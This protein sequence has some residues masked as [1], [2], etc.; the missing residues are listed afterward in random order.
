MSRALFSC[1]GGST[2]EGEQRALTAL[3]HAAPAEQTPS[4]RARSAKPVGQLHVYG[5][6]YASRC[7]A[8]GTAEAT[9]SVLVRDKNQD[10]EYAD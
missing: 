9:S 2:P 6:P 5:Y 4:T 10:M 3:A 8:A 7:P 1:R